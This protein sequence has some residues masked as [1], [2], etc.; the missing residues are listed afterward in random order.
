M[1]V[2][3]EG[4][5]TSGKSTQISLLK[6]HFKS[7]FFTKEPGGSSFGQTLRTMLLNGKESLSPRAEALLFLADRA[8]NITQNIQP[9]KNGLIISDRS[10]VSGIAYAFFD[11]K[12]MIELNL[13][14]TSE[15]LPEK[16]VILE[17]SKNA[18][19]ARLSQK[20]HDKI[21]ARGIDYLLEIQERLKQAAKALEISHIC[22]NAELKKEEINEK[23]IKF[24]S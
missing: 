1:Y 13:F 3:I 14:A 7:A 21:E 12:T 2:A 11:M 15:I 8:Q 19:I 6:N 23:I 4:I 10:L 5:D 22:I 16:I 9:N 18:L 17:L 24:I 20:E